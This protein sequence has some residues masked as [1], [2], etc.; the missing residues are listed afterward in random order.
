[1]TLGLLGL[2]FVQGYWIKKAVKLKEQQFKYYVNQSLTA[3]TNEMEQREALLY[4]VDELVFSMV[5]SAAKQL[6]YNFPPYSAVPIQSEKEK[7]KINEIKIETSTSFYKHN[8]Y[9]SEDSQNNSLS[10]SNSIG[11]STIDPDMNN[12]LEVLSYPDQIVNAYLK[13][14][15]N[16]KTVIIN[17]VMDKMIKHKPEVEERIDFNTINTLLEKEFKKRGINI[18]YQFA[19]KKANAGLV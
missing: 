7:D 8:Y 3:V 13:Q 6:L 11:L 15:V 5:D 19:V 17:K 9:L 10:I 12:P 1:M 18:N 14:K 4:V 16:N 2:I